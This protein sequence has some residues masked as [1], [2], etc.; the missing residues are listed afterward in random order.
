ML[1]KCFKITQIQNG[2]YVSDNFEIVKSLKVRSLTHIAEHICQFKRRYDGNIFQKALVSVSLLAEV[3]RLDIIY[4]II[5]ILRNKARRQ[6]E[7]VSASNYC[8]KVKV[9]L[10]KWPQIGLSFKIYTS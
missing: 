9:I 8:L 2:R 10:K 1:R 7:Y 3:D 4:K 6:R 5:E